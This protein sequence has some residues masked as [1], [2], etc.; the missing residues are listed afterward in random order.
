MRILGIR[1]DEEGYD[2]VVWALVRGRLFMV[3][4]SINAIS[5]DAQLEP[6]R[7]GCC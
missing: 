7:E 2:T 3:T 1:K 5:R 4:V 6:T